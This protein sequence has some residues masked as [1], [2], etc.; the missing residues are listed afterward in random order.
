M[1]ALPSRAAWFRYR[2][3]AGIR[4]GA[5]DPSRRAFLDLGARSVADLL[6]EGGLRAGHLAELMALGEPMPEPARYE[7]PVVPSKILCMAKNYEAHAREFGAA[8]PPEPV[9][10][11]KLPDSLL[12]HGQ[13]VRIPEHLDSRVDH[14]AELGVVLG[15]P[16]PERRGAKP[17]SED[18]ALS[19]VAGYTC[20]NDV[21]A[22]TLQGRDREAKLPWLRSK[23]FDTFCPTGPFVVPADALDASD[24][25]ITMT[26]NGEIRQSGSTSAMVHGI[27][28]ILVRM[29]ACT[30][31]RPGDLIATGTPAGVGPIRSGDIM[32]VAIEGIGA[33]S[34][35]V[36]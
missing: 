16:D 11:A 20:L 25:A 22:R 36:Q 12:P 5:Y 19:L 31:L 14:E 8:P 35:P 27:G 33:L 24:L 2:A 28:A 6:A 23:S 26:V 13:P 10:F 17:S 30:T 7:V 3:G 18:E 4:L 34:N 32:T 29:A 1:G 9:F 15:F 21:T